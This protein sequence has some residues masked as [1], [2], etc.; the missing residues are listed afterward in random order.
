MNSQQHAE[1]SCVIAGRRLGKQ[2]LIMSNLY[3]GRLSAV[4][5]DTLFVLQLL[6]EKGKTGPIPG[7]DILAIINKRRDNKIA[8]TNFRASCHTL[9]ERQLLLKYRSS[10]LQLA[11]A[12][13]DDG[14][15]LAELVYEDRMK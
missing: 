12:L 8:P 13:S 9:V 10:S 4:Q 6:R 2:Q 5:R 15:A 3:K 7:V 11:F 1:A 14:K